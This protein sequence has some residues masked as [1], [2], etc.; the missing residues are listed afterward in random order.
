MFNPLLS[1]EANFI[2]GL[3]TPTT[4]MEQATTNIMECAIVF[5]ANASAGSRY[6]AG[7]YMGSRLSPG[8][9]EV[10]DDRLVF[11]VWRL[12][13]HT[14]TG[15]VGDLQ[16]TGKNLPRDE[17][18]GWPTLGRLMSLQALNYGNS[19]IIAFQLH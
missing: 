11:M 9:N 14:V 13:M 10:R 15:Y 17:A 12:L 18:T 6:R 2:A 16:Q 4:S 8:A 19:S 5:I 3:P 1:L 7:E